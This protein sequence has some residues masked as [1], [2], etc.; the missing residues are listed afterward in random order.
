MSWEDTFRVWANGPSST[1]QDKCDNAHR[2]I[3]KAIEASPTLQGRGT[4]VYTQGS[5]RNR[6][7]VRLESDVDIGVMSAET[8]F[9]DL[10]NGTTA[11]D[12]GLSTPPAYPYNQY[13]ND[14]EQALVNHFGRR[15]VVRGS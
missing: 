4:T 15:A 7:N 3:T 1:E 10:P 9:F 2:A 8:F 14:V 6:T 12:F 13:K 5:Y 11:Q